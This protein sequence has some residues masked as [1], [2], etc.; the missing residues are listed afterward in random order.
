M[1]QVQHPIVAT[2][3]PTIHDCH[4]VTL[5]CKQCYAVT[6]GSAS[7]KKG[8]LVAAEV[9]GSSSDSSDSQYAR[10]HTPN[11][12]AKLDIFLNFFH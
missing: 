1:L 3:L 4:M 7:L 12:L 5:T 11:I 8:R 10:S 9:S 2:S 6:L